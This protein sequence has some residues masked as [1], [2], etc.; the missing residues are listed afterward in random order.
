VIE[1]LPEMRE[2]NAMC[3]ERRRRALVWSEQLRTMSAWTCASTAGA[4]PFLRRKWPGRLSDIVED[5]G[6]FNGPRFARIPCQPPHGVDFLSQRDA[7][8]IRP[9]AR[10]I[11]HPGFDNRLLFVQEGSLLVGGHGTLGEGEI[12]GQVVPV[13]PSL[14]KCAFTQD[15]L[16]IQPKLTYQAVACAFLSTRVGLR[17]LR[18]TAVGTKILSM[19]IDLLRDLPFPNLPGDEAELVSEHLKASIEARERAQAA[20]REAIGIVEEKVLPAWLD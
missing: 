14:A 11:V 20:E 2:A 13:S 17:L 18:S 19:R 1:E 3:A 6:V 5:G 12:F 8:L 16:R 4:L 10:R 9:V 7:F 15:L